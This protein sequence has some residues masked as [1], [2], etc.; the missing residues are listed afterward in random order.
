MPIASCGWHGIKNRWLGLWWR[1][2]RYSLLRVELFSGEDFLFGCCFL[3]LWSIIARGA[4]ES[5]LNDLVNIDWMVRV[6]AAGCRQKWAS[7]EL[8]GFRHLGSPS[9]CCSSFMVFR[10]WAL[11]F[12]GW[13]CSLHHWQLWQETVD[14]GAH[15][16]LCGPCSTRGRRASSGSTDC[17]VPTSE[18]VMEKNNHYHW[19]SWS[20]RLDSDQ[21]RN[22]DPH[23]DHNP[24]DQPNVQHS[25]F[26][27]KRGPVHP[28]D[29]YKLAASTINGS[30]ASLS[31]HHVLD[32]A[33]QNT[34]LIHS[35]KSTLDFV[36]WW[37]DPATD[38]R[39]L[40]DDPFYAFIIISD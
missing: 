8:E 35:I 5:G 9:G 26:E 36:Y 19:S 31:H 25:E 12:G 33:M 15:Y 11:L 28:L 37:T 39:K 2:Q 10:C 21:R 1:L 24:I 16:G 23:F 22:S 20:F 4:A 3:P 30:A 17:F 7:G 27:C 38:F 13:L 34:L 40:H 14:W 29:P 32:S 6:G 18:S